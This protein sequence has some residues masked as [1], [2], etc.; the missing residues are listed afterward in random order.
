MP[1][2][3]NPRSSKNIA[4][5]KAIGEMLS[6]MTAPSR[7]TS[8]EWGEDRRFL[9]SD[10]TS[11]PGKL[12]CMQTPWMLYLLECLDNPR[13]KT[14]V[15]KKSAQIAWTETI[16][17]YIG[18]TME[19]D[20]RNIMI[21]FP[22]MRS[23]QKFYKEKLLPMIQSTPV[24]K[25]LVGSI[26]RISANH[27]PFPGGFIA[28]AT[29]GSAEDMKS[30]VIPIVIVEEPDGV[31][32]DV[33]NQGDGMSILRQRMKSFI[34]SKLI[35]AGTP[36]DF[37]YS[38]VHIAYEA[39]NKLEYMVPCHEC[40]KFHT[41][42][43][44]N[45]KYDIFQNRLISPL[46]GKYNPETAYYECPHCQNIWSFKQKNK[47]VLEAIK[48]FNKGWQVTN[49]AIEDVVGFAYNELLSCFEK[50]SFTELAKQYLRAQVMYEQGTEGLMK[51]FI[52]NSMGEAYQPIQAGV[53]VEE[54][55]TKRLNYPEFIVPYDGLILT[56]GIDVQHNR[57][58]IVVRAWGRNNNSWLVCWTEIFGD[59]L[60]PD[61]SV[62]FRLSDMMMEDWEHAAGGGKTLKIAAISIDSADGST[63]E[64]VYRWALDMASRHNHVFCI[65]GMGEGKNTDYE[66][67]NEPGAMEVSTGQQVRR[68]LASTM[69]VNLFLV[70]VYKAHCE[71]LRRINLTGPKDR[72]YHNETSYGGYE[73]GILSCVQLYND[74]D[75]RGG[76]LKKPASAKEAIDC[77]KYA[78]HAAYAIQ[79]RNYT[80]AHWDKIT[81]YLHQDKYAVTTKEI[82]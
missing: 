13:V 66:I 35:Y 67:F 51:S 47:N 82:L 12:D 69:G 19:L 7:M 2:M 33:N 11:R 46:Y 43:F 9:T 68:S 16:N 49:G 44:K 17:T 18:R 25:R 81:K 63:T 77:E 78:L 57:F 4:E 60:D 80:N 74:G 28:L 55:R 24:L 79:I 53:D 40:K 64:L 6:R 65:R 73:E 20:P 61:D 50:S 8:R 52:N 10:I 37:G 3:P 14:I 5:R 1:S 23:S 30:S 72:Y 59:V 54:F 71:I 56:C 70:G 38:Q 26:A 27:I 58:A 31:K 76:F 21:A 75:K 32:K 39:S 45:L 15:G 42:D 48:Y 36:T 41:L 62:W 22:R 29:A 34:D